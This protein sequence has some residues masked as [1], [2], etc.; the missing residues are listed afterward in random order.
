MGIAIQ[1]SLS[2]RFE[3]THNKIY[4][5]RGQRHKEVSYLD[6]LGQ[7]VNGSRGVLAHVLI[8]Q[9]SESCGDLEWDYFLI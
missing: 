2:R 9:S 1:V 3:Q 8:S 5:T 7:C 6:L 4:L